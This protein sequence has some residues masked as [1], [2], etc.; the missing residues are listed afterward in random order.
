MLNLN[1]YLSVSVLFNSYHLTRCVKFNHYI[2]A[3]LIFI[4]LAQCST[5][6]QEPLTPVIKLN[7]TPELLPLAAEP[8]ATRHPALCGL[9][10][11]S[12]FMY[13]RALRFHND[14]TFSFY[15]RGCTGKEY[16][17]GRW[18]QIGNEV[19]LTSFDK[20]KQEQQP[21]VV[22]ESKPVEI[23]ETKPAGITRHKKKTRKGGLIVP[24]IN[25]TYE[26][27]NPVFISSAKISDT[28]NYYFDHERFI[29]DGRNLYELG[30]D[31]TR[32]KYIAT[33]DKP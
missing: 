3:G 20:Y 16:T 31:G 14:G 13:S 19:A 6:K 10:M 1:D 11:N 30:K 32:N 28:S 15:D 9:W 26:F 23:T 21:F 25:I 2:S 22:T 4:L 29:Y 33:S 8:D 12:I 24:D 27:I 17:E 5:N 18:E 7:I